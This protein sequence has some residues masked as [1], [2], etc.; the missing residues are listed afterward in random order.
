[1]FVSCENQ[2]GKQANAEKLLGLEDETLRRSA[3]PNSLAEN[4]VCI[5]LFVQEIFFFLPKKD[6]EL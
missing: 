6:R 5:F 4:S 2:P 1:M 3:E